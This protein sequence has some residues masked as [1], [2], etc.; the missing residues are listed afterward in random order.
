LLTVWQQVLGRDDIGV[1]DDFFTVGGHSLLAIR[2]LK[3]IQPVLGIELPLSVIF[4][5]PS[6]RELAR[7]AGRENLE[8]K[9]NSLMLLQKAS[10]PQRSV[11]LIPPNGHTGIYFSGLVSKLP[12]SI[13]AYSFDPVTALEY[14]S[15]ECIAEH[16]AEEIMK[17]QAHGPW[18]IGGVCFGNHLALATANALEKV[19][20]D[21][22]TLLLVDS[23]APFNGPSWQRESGLVARR[24]SPIGFYADIF[25]KAWQQDK[26]RS[27]LA[28]QKRRVHGLLNDTVNTYNKVQYHL[29]MLYVRHVAMPTQSKITLILSNELIERPLLVSRWQSLALTDFD[30]RR[31][32]VEKHFD[33][34]DPK[35][36]YWAEYAALLLAE[37]G[38]S[39][40]DPPSLGD[41]QMRQD[42]S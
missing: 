33:F 41:P 10:S 15:I 39:T 24:R 34:V 31:S 13:N 9:P 26:F 12:K 27:L 42:I 28:R 30:L 22:S 6:V 29:S 23:D 37:F 7:F 1:T 5:V 17:I 16:Y 25:A 18:V 35:S 11:F 40:V 8:F 2:L 38:D 32:Q 14:A 19:T 20:G 3:R 4:E 21:T 36:S